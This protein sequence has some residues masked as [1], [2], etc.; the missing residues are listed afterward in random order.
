MAMLGIL[1]GCA[2]S[3]YYFLGVEGGYLREGIVTATTWIIVNWGLDVIALLP[4]THQTLPQYFM[5]IG[6]EYLGMFGPLTAI[7]Y[8]LE[9]NAARAAS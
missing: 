4:F 7:G 6:I 9:R 2:F 8:L 1:V 3:A 5:E